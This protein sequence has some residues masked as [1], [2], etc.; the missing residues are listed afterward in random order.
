MFN[1]T[2][3]FIDGRVHAKIAVADG[4]SCFITTANLTGYAMEKNIKV[5]G[6]LI[7]GG[8]LPRQLDN[9]IANRNE[10]DCSSLI[11]DMCGLRNR[12]L[13]NILSS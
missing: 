4:N 8:E 1:K 5:G 10:C 3:E 2:E 11:F 9:Q 12:Y 7:S 13:I 6:G